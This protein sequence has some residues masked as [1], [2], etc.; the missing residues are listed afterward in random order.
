MIYLFACT[1]SLCSDIVAYNICV[2]YRCAAVKLRRIKY[3]VS[4]ELF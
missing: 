3:H 1:L 4:N 2:C